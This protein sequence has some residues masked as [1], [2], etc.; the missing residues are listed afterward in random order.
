MNQ[1]SVL[2]AIEVCGYDRHFA[3][4][5]TALVEESSAVAAAMLSRNMRHGHICLDF[6]KG[7]VEFAEPRPAFVWPELKTWKKAFAKSR[8][9]GRPEEGRPLVLDDVGRFYLRR[10]WKYEQA[11]AQRILVRCQQS[12]VP[13]C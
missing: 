2:L 12:A 10:Y 4:F 7:P 1:T 6:G 5:V 9:I 8:A 3:G 11:L 13:N